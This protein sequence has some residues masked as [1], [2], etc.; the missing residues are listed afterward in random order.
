MQNEHTFITYP[1]WKKYIVISCFVESLRVKDKR[2]LFHIM[3]KSDQ[4]S[5]N[6]F[7]PLYGITAGEFAIWQILSEHRKSRKKDEKEDDLG[8]RE[9]MNAT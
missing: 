7:F 6:T 8:S 3:R 2:H 5:H 4:L 9:A 1:T